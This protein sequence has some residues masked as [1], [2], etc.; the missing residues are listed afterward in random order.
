[1]Q[2]TS[3]ISLGMGDDNGAFTPTTFGFTGGEEATAIMEAVV[4]MLRA[5]KVGVCYSAG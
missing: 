2:D 1:V 3:K 5:A 4:G